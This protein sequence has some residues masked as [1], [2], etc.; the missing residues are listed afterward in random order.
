MTDMRE[1][2]SVDHMMETD[3]EAGPEATVLIILIDIVLVV[4]VLVDTG[5]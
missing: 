1:A 5:Q 3:N 4:E 2:W